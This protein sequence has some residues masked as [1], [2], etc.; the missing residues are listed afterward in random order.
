MV[1]DYTQIK[2]IANKI[3]PY[4]ITVERNSG[5]IVILK[6]GTPEY[7]KDLVLKAHGDPESGIFFLQDDWRYEFV[8]DALR[9]IVDTDDLEDAFESITPNVYTAELTA[10]LNSNIQRIYYLNDAIQEMVEI[11]AKYDGFTLLA[12]AQRIERVEVFN[13]IVDELLELIDVEVVND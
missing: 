2:N 4:F 13:L 7:I 11:G 10:W 12:R 9:A 3:L 8:H 5:L 1:D 6:N